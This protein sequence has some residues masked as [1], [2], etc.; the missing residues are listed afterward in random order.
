MTRV[1]CV[2]GLCGLC[3]LVVTW[4]G[5]GPGSQS[6]SRGAWVLGVASSRAARLG[7]WAGLSWAVLLQPS[8]AA[9]LGWVS[10]IEQAP[11][12]ALLFAVPHPSFC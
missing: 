4:V 6:C 8:A 3:G 2:W 1:C 9:S 12:G 5:T 11:R 7:S 10:L